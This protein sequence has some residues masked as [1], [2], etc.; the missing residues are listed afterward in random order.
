MYICDDCGESCKGDYHG[1]CIKC[2]NNEIRY[3]CSHHT[4]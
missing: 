3:R 4:Y 1:R 2:S